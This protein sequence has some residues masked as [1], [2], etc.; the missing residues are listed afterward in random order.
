MG[1]VLVIGS[2][3]CDVTAFADRL[4]GRGETVLGR[5]LTLVLGGKGAN[6]AVAAARAG[7]RTAMV[8]H[9]GR[10]PFAEI[11]LAG[12]RDNGVE[13]DQ[14]TPVDG[15]TGVA[16]IRVADGENDIVIVPL[17]NDHV[18]A[19]RVDQALAQ[20]E[21]GDVLLLQ[22]EIPAATTA[23][24]AR[25]GHEAGLLVV[26]DPAPAVEL[27]ESVWAD[28]DVVT[29]NETE[30]AAITG[31]TDEDAAARW[32]LDRG[33]A[34]VILTLGGHGVLMATSGGS[35]RHDAYEVEA[36]D[37]TAAGDAFTGTLGATLAAGTPLAE[38]VPRAMAAG[39]L[40]VTKPG[41]SP[42]LPSATEIDTFLEQRA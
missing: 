30:A 19:A 12:L 11:A 39:A 3:T 4:P 26:L 14:V 34:T 27:P 22:L 28:V 31:E 5:E 29:P 17:A 2:I 41:A 16:H 35:R 37:T 38:A 33:V 36:V 18:D 13:T 8:G 23:H 40:A 25:A 9:V 42:S 6:Q 20:A 1:R 21:P 15:P 32:F 10:D 24:A 7:A